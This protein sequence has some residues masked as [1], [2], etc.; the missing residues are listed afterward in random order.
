MAAAILL[1]LALLCPLFPG[2]AQDA[3]TG[4]EVRVVD[5]YFETDMK[6]FIEPSRHSEVV[7]RIPFLTPVRVSISADPRHKGY[8][9]VTFMGVDGFVNVTTLQKMPAELPD[10]RA[11]RTLF[12]RDLRVL[13]AQTLAGA[14]VL[15][16]LL[17]ETPFVVLARTRFMMKVEARG[18]VGFIY[19][20][21]LQELQ[22][23]SALEPHILYSKREQGLL[24]HPL[25]GAE[26][27]INLSAGQLLTV[28]ARNRGYYRVEADGRSGYVSMDGTGQIGAVADE[29]MLVY[30][31]ADQL[32]YAGVN[33]NIPS[34]QR[35]QAGRLYP[36]SGQAGAFM[37]LKDSGL[38][39]KADSVRA[40][41][42]SAFSAPRLAS[43]AA[44]ES[45]YAMP[46]DASATAATLEPGRLYTFMAASG[47]WWYVNDGLAEGFVKSRALGR[48]PEKGETMNRT[49]AVY[50]GTASFLPGS[51]QPQPVVPGEA[52]SLTQLFGGEWFR[53]ADGAFVH[54]GNVRF[55]GSDAPV[56]PHRVTATAGLVLLSLPDAELGQPLLAL[57]EGEPLEVIGFSRSYLLARAR[58]LE[59]YVKGATL[60]TQETRYL[61]DTD[62]PPYEILVNRSDFSVSVYAL[63]ADGRRVGEPVRREVAALGKRT[64]PTPP[65]RYLLGFK[66]RWVR[67]PNTQAPHGITYLRGRYLHGIPC[68]GP[69]ESRMADWAFE[70]LGTFST[71]GCVRMPFD[72][73]AF[74][75]FNCPSY[76]TTME[77]VNGL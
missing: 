73:A 21:D 23:D 75:Y 33:E 17:P 15:A 28:T 74:I 55:I 6:V 70:E 18:Q 69:D 62:P 35:M 57:E 52:V 27:A 65:G 58:G 46:D 56:T 48:L 49:H 7:Q 44:P 25:A 26:A 12:A 63:D 77:V 3:Q 38:F 71:G 53:T 43:V 9:Q 39:V 72:M 42:L 61:P 2:M 47:S 66:Q 13:R 41:L 30:A 32:L 19:A 31:A 34:G 4:Y 60:K 67:F 59:G 37:Q 24:S 22:P 54:R 16:R 45:L 5:G 14:E 51:S 8:G 50:T 29:T 1:L 68:Y 20:N 10:E 64:T 36:V 40:I 11:G 76:Q